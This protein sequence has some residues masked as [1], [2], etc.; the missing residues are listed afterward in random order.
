MAIFFS[1]KT[2]LRLKNILQRGSDLLF[3]IQND[4][5]TFVNEILI[6]VSESIFI[7]MTEV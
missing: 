4:K 6:V 1:G 3:F 2:V 7:Q 5:N